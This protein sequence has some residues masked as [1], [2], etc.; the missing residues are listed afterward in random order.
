[1]KVIVT[2]FEYETFE[3][4]LEVL[5]RVG[6]TLH[7]EQCH[8]EEEVIERC[9]DAHA[10]LNQYASITRRVIE[11]LPHLKVIA[12][13]GVGFN[14]VDIEAATEHG[15]VVCNVTDYCLGEVSDHTMA[16]LLDSARKVTK[17]NNSIESGVW[18]FNVSAPLYRLAGRTLGLVGFGN[19]PQQVARKAQ[20][21]DLHVIAY[22]PFMD[23]A[24]AKERG[25]TLV[26]LEQLCEQ[27]DFISVHVPLNEQ[28][29]HLISTDE[30]NLMKKESIL[31][32]TARG[33]IIDEQALIVALEQGQ[34]AGAALDV[35]ETEPI[36]SDHPFLTMDQVILTPHAAFYSVEAEE[37]LK[38]K[39]A[40]NVAHVLTGKVPPYVVNRD[41]LSKLQLKG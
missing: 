18:N 35:L 9:Q 17:L 1:M 34:I 20:A 24:Y 40:D 26:S 5:E 8:T 22:D 11:A 25:V 33:P 4:E 16:L 10:L 41:V 7:Y 39:T 36:A 27:S 6:L 38:R 32:N 3:P 29:H 21:F 30:L 15:V 13:Y 19:I 31:I 23:E 37:E 12:R 2:D 28:T 14:T